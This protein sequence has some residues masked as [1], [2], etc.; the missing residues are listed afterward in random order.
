MLFLTTL[1]SFPC[2]E[3]MRSCCC[4]RIRSSARF[5]FDSINIAAALPRIPI[6]A[7]QIADNKV[8]FL[9]QASPLEFL[10]T[11]QAKRNLSSRS[12][13]GGVLSAT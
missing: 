11:T 7:A 9:C 3:L 2:T 4:S 5:S 10:I 12:G 1:I 6:V 8:T 13:I